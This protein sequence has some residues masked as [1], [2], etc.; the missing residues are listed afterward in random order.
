MFSETSEAVWFS[1][2]S[3][4]LR[5]VPLFIRWRQIH[6]ALYVKNRP[7]LNYVSYVIT[8]G[9][10]VIPH[11][12]YLSLASFAVRLPVL[13]SKVFSVFVRDSYSAQR[14]AVH[15]ERTSCFHV[16]TVCVQDKILR[17]A[18]FPLVHYTLGRTPQDMIRR[19]A[20]SVSHGIA[21]YSLDKKY[22]T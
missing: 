11:P 21:I 7:H 14:V 3:E 15:A 22:H 8:R 10:K 1:S 5:Y 9:T 13:Q 18:R 6:L 17:N 20:I 16:S 2:R 4:I 19:L 12:D